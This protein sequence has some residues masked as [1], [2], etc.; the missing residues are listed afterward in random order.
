MNQFSQLALTAN[1]ELP[2]TVPIAPRN[3]QMSEAIQKYTLSFR[4]GLVR[5]LFMLLCNAMDP[6]LAIPWELVQWRK[7]MCFM[8]LVND[9]E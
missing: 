4:M 6:K 8:T 5:T 1:E 3:A 9:S 2:R 7:M